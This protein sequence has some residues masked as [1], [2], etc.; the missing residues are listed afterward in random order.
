MGRGLDRQREGEGKSVPRRTD[1]HEQS[2][3][4]KM[5]MA[6]LGG[7]RGTNMQEGEV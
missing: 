6:C 1:R 3:W 7:Q 2:L 4:G 5:T